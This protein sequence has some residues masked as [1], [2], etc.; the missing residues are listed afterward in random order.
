METARIAPAT[1]PFAASI[2]HTIDKVMRGQPPLT[3]FTTLARDDRLASKFFAGGL[4]DKGHLSLRD[5][6]LVIDRTTARCGSEYEWGVH[7]AIFGEAASLTEAQ[8]HSLVNG[9]PTDAC[10]QPHETTLLQFCD[11][12]HDACDIDDTLWARVKAHYSD[13]AV[14]ELLMLAGFYRTVSYL[15]NALRLPLEDFARR[16]PTTKN[17]PA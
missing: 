5:R 17:A 1:P 16:F 7:I 14:L 9:D 13:D 3:L 10:W 8:I 15:T 6:E 2:Q 12:L 11:A 4:L